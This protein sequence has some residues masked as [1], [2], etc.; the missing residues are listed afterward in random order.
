MALCHFPGEKGRDDDDDEVVVEEEEGEECISVEH[1]P[2][3]HST[4]G[5]KLQLCCCHSRA[6]F[7]RL[8]PPFSAILHSLHIL[9]CFP[10]FLGPCRLILRFEP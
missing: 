2:S 4:A 6:E 5:K 8:Q 1:I 3:L 9:L 10:S 7:I